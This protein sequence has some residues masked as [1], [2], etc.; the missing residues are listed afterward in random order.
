[1]ALA[2]NNHVNIKTHWHQIFTSASK[3]N[4]GKIGGNIHFLNM[5]FVVCK[6]CEA[7]LYLQACLL[8]LDIIKTNTT[9]E[10]SATKHIPMLGFEIGDN[11]WRP[12][13]TDD[14]GAPTLMPP[15][16]TYRNLWDEWLIPDPFKFTWGDLNLCHPAHR[17]YVRLVDR[18]LQGQIS[19]WSYGVSNATGLKAYKQFEKFAERIHNL[20]RYARG[21]YAE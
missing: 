13:L 16:S 10:W 1:M 4:K 17:D 6:A 14:K 19:F 2:S 21:K 9:D 20:E 3:T 7:D 15:Y 5:K 12:Y 18:T 8:Q 11:V